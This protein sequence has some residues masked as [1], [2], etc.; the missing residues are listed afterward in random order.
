MK[1]HR[2]TPQYNFLVNKK[3]K[4]SIVKHI[5]PGKLENINIKFEEGDIIITPYKIDQKLPVKVLRDTSY[6][7]VDSDLI[8]N[9]KSFANMDSILEVI[10]KSR[11][12]YLLGALESLLD[13]RPLLSLLRKWLIGDDKREL[14]FLK[15]TGKPSN[16]LFFRKW[17]DVEGVCDLFVS[18]GFEINY[19][20]ASEVSVNCSFD[21][22][23]DFLD[24][25]RLPKSKIKHIIFTREHPDYGIT[26]GIGSYVKEAINLYGPTSTVLMIDDLENPNN[27]AV[28]D[29][30][31][32]SVERLI[33]EEQYRSFLNYDF[34]NSA[35]CLLESLYQV[36][37]LY[38]D[39]EFVE[40]SDY[41]HLNLSRIIQ[42]KEAGLLPDK[43]KT[44]T[45]CHGSNIYTNNA[46]RRYPS[47]DDIPTIEKEVYSIINSD[48]TIYLTKFVEGLYAEYGIKALN[49][50]KDR[51]PM[52]M[53]YYEDRLIDMPL[54][55]K[56][57][58]NI[59]YIGK[60]SKMK[61]GDIF[62]R[63]AIEI[64]KRGRSYNIFCASTYNSTEIEIEESLKE[65]RSYPNVNIVI[66]PF[67]RDDLISEL[68]SKAEDSIAIIPYPGDNHPNVIL[69]L[70]L[71]GMDFIASDQ[72][73]I[74]ELIPDKDNF[75]SILQPT[76][77]AEAFFYI[78]GD[79][80]ARYKI[81]KDNRDKYMKAQKRINNGYSLNKL[82]NLFNKDGL[83][84]ANREKSDSVG[85]IIPCYNTDYSYI[86]DLCNSL[87]SQSLKPEKILFVDDGSTLDGYDKRL[88]DI[89]SKKLPQFNC[90]VVKKPNGGLSSARNYGLRKLSTRY[91]VTIDSDDVVDNYF[92]ENM[93]NAISANRDNKT[94]GFTPF[95]NMFNDGSDFT[96]Y[97]SFS[98]QY[99][100]HGSN[101][102]TA[103]F[104]HNTYGSASCIFE[105]E[106]L[107]ELTGGWDDSSRAM[108]EDWSLYIKIN[109][110]GH[111]VKILPIASYFYRVRANSMVRTYDNVNGNKLL[112][113]NYTSIPRYDAYLMF[114]QLHHYYNNSLPL[115]SGSDSSTNALLQN[116]LNAY[117]GNVN[118][119]VKISRLVSIY[120]RTV[121]GNFKTLIRYIYLATFKTLKKVYRT[122]K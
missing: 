2:I 8:H 76:N 78:S 12:V 17:D 69:E 73:G 110:L 97:K 30:R 116:L 103:F 111:K 38:P 42:A 92:L 33:G 106:K 36:L 105:R 48:A 25:N 94:I 55:F 6:C 50:K 37:F 83:I 31:W 93:V 96:Y 75:T 115:V 72:G 82:Y 70:M 90:E 60:L 58:K 13:I 101:L 121:P 89:V 68:N 99:M 119:I 45:V 54:S 39:I 98:S 5:N 107:I 100:P 102:G 10:S 104:P 1:L 47:K 21:S 74:P 49:P 40:G 95:L 9:L 56:P 122:I 34:G 61:G 19:I 65:L 44:I 32:L 113:S 91:V 77:I 29:N 120:D 7:S 62:L 4:T 81:V 80:L 3:A 26:G 71:V 86:E 22:Y 27:K 59:Y 53:A 108:Y 63:S 18:S 109:S 46:A 16:A 64:A 84:D 79:R 14:I 41:G 85:I 15:D 117:D 66:Q 112:I 118:R 52:N 57:V 24:N 23:N 88:I 28:E 114:S 11:K 20:S 43:L 87:G 35:Y 51:L 67:N